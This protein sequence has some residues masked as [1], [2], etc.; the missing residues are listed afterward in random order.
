MKYVMISL[1]I[2]LS[3]GAL[4][5]LRPAHAQTPA[6]IVQFDTQ[7]GPVS[8]CQTHAG[9][10]TLCLGTDGL[11][12][13]NA[14]AKY[15]PNLAIPTSAAGGITGVTMNGIAVPVS[16]GVAAVTGVTNLTINGLTKSANA[17]F[18]LSTPS[19]VTVQ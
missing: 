12:F 9:V 10:S 1:A 6:S 19:T 17:S 15:G 5:L 18:L 7:Q 14:G 4:M 2:A 16:N 8:G 13:S 11:V 3:L